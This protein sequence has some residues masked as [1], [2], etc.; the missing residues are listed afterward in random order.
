MGSFK[1]SRNVGGK[2]GKAKAAGG[3][4]KAAKT[5]VKS[6]EVA[7]KGGVEEKAEEEIAALEPIVPDAT[8]WV[9]DPDVVWTQVVA[10]SQAR[11]MVTIK[12]AAGATRQINLKTRTIKDAATSSSCGGLK[13]TRN[14]PHGRIGLREA[15]WPIEAQRHHR[16]QDNKDWAG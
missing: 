5:A 11:L 4:W 12:D 2:A 9:S 8:Y 1:S 14:I 15:W 16:G 7:A 10:V 6:G 13:R 3:G